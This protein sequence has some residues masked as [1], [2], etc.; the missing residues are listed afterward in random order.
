MSNFYQMR[1]GDFW[2]LIGIIIFAC[3]S[4]L[5]WSRRLIISGLALFGWMMAAL[6][7]LSPLFVLVRLLIERHNRAKENKN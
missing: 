3:I 5:P 2:Y 6:M 7:V 1:R 4:F